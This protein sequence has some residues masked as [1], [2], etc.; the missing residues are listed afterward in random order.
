MIREELKH[1]KT[2]PRDLRK[3]GL[4]VG[5]VFAFLGL[6]LWLRHKPAWPWF[7]APAAPLIGLGLVWPQAL[8]W[9]YV[10]WMALAFTLGAIVSTV[11]LT[12]FFCVV[13]TPVGLLARVLGRDFL[14]RKL[15]ANAA[16]YWLPRPASASK[17]KAD[18]E[19]Q[20]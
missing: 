8:R 6:V 18:Y 1:L 7:C 15:E 13:I 17:Q 19:R 2:G 4:T 20:F 10:G 12:V 16:S 5:G 3:F 14:S 11:L 9:V